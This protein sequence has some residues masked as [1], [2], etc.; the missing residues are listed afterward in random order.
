MAK[1]PKSNPFATFIANKLA[2]APA[3]PKAAP[4]KKAKGK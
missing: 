1:T 4:K 3:P 2:E